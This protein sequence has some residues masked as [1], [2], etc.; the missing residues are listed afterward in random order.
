MVTEVNIGCQKFSKTTF[1]IRIGN[2]KE[3]P[4]KASDA[5]DMLSLAQVYDGK[6][7][8]NLNEFVDAYKLDKSFN[9]N[10]RINLDFDEVLEK[11]KK[12]TSENPDVKVKED[13]RPSHKPS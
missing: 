9:N 3:S 7:L 12:I 10:R 5:K 2:Q 4:I 6:R 8:S 11:A 13:N 1:N